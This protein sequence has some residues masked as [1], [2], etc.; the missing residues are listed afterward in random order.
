MII[1]NKGLQCFHMLFI[2]LNIFIVGVIIICMIIFFDKIIIAVIMHM[3]T[4]SR[5]KRFSQVRWGILTNI[6]TGNF[7]KYPISAWYICILLSQW[8]K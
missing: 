1:L 3:Q 6:L 7:C 4:K 2:T 5:D 8:L